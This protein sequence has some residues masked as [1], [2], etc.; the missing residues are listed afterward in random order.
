MTHAGRA[1]V[2]VRLWAVVLGFAV[3]LA[4]Q[5]GCVTKSNERKARVERSEHTTTHKKKSGSVRDRKRDRRM[6]AEE[7]PHQHPTHEHPHDHPH[8]PSSHHHHQHPHPHLEGQNGHH[9]PY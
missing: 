1:L 8:E 9:H 7:E 2:R 6:V 3:L 4:S 5:S